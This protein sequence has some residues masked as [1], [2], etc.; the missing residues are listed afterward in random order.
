MKKLS[1]ILALML[2][3]VMMFTML[4]GC[5]EAKEKANLKVFGIAS[6]VT[7]E[8]L[9][10]TDVVKLIADQTGEIVEY[11]QAPS[12]AA[13]AQTAIFN[14]FTNK[15]DYHSVMVTK[16]QFFTLLSQGALMDISSLVNGTTNMKNVIGETG[17]N[18]AKK[19]GKIYG[20]P[21]KDAMKCSAMGLAY[22]MDWLAA[23]NDDAAYQKKAGT[24]KITVPSKANNFSMTTA[25]FKTY[26]TYVKDKGLVSDKPFRVDTNNVY[27]ENILPAFGVYQE[28]ADVDGKLTYAINQPGFKDYLNYMTDLFN[29][30]LIS[31][32][33]DGGSNGVKQI[34]LKADGKYIEKPAA[35]V[36]RVAHWNAATADDKIGYLSALVANE[37]DEPYL[38]ATEGYSYFTVIPKFVDKDVAERVVKMF[39]KKLEKDFFI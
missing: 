21:N 9:N 10:K 4:A 1:S 7:D 18:M 28:W 39:D 20:I 22:R 34:T 11:Y 17:W 25:N 23:Y 2:A 36:A 33:G 38:F 26:L 13:D 15:L 24:A 35:G 27:Q 5:G 12:V 31:Y 37:G 3:I 6:G 29:S 30:G 32:N 16:Q 19:D 8:E 14:I